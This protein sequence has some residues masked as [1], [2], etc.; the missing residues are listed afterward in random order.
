MIDTYFDGITMVF[1]QVTVVLCSWKFGR[2]L[3]N[4]HYVSTT[5]SKVIFIV[6][7]LQISTA[8]GRSMPKIG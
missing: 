8:L 3:K 6:I 5:R 1:A 2:S 7:F 4:M